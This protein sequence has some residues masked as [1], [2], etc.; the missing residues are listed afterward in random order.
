M[1][2]GRSLLLAPLAASV[3]ERLIEALGGIG[4]AAERALAAGPVV[5]G[6]LAVLGIVAL[7]VALRAPRPL[8][9][10]GG[11]VVG[12]LAGIAARGTLALHFGLSPVTS[13]AVGAALAALACG[14]FPPIFPFALGALPGALFG[15]HAPIGGRGAF[16]AA[17]GALVGGTIALV[18]ARPVTAGFT[19]LAGGLLAGA[20]LLAVFAGH[21]LTVELAGRP[22]ALLGFALVTGIAGAAFQL[23]RR[24]GS[25]GGEGPPVEDREG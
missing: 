5:G 17:A 4:L 24:E 18:F 23:A 11:A 3:T 16:G 21:P 9:A 2:A 22:F 8:A 1:S 19:A 10:A 6:V 15:V 14:A 12:A 7:T 25:S 13:A 20:G